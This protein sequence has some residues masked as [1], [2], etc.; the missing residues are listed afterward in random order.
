[1]TDGRIQR[2][3]ELAVRFG[4]NVQPGQIVA[5]IAETGQE[6]VARLVADEAYRAGAKYVDVFYFDPH[7]K[8]SRLL[9]APAETLEYVPPWYGER[10]LHVGD[11]HGARI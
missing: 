7:V 3:A 10:A 4:A 5:M 9:H 8:H 1:V 6:D 2:L 11:E